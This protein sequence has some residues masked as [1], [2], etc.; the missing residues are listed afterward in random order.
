MPNLRITHTMKK[1]HIAHTTLHPTIHKKY[2]SKKNTHNSHHKHIIHNTYSTPSK[3]KIQ[4]LHPY[5]QTTQNTYIKT[6]G[7]NTLYPKYTHGTAY[8]HN[9][10]IQKIHT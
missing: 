6:N 9:V 7:L 4:A 10:H 1:T 3:Q 8:K 2:T 5:I